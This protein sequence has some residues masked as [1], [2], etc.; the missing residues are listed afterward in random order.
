M[1]KIATIS[2]LALSLLLTRGL[3]AILLWRKAT[4]ITARPAELLPADCLFVAELVDLHQSAIRWPGMELNKLFEEPEVKAF[5]EKPMAHWESQS[6]QKKYTADLM[7][8]LPRQAFVAVPGLEG[9]S[10]KMVG[11]FSFAGDQGAAE[12]LLSEPRK[13]LKEKHPAGRAE[14]QTHGK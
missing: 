5:L 14:I 4:A 6:S 8:T 2:V 7:K 1:K 11:G 10:V 3:A 13:Q 12:R 9:N